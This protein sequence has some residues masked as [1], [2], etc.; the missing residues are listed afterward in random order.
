MGRNKKPGISFYRMDSGHVTN[1]KVRLLMN[2]FDTDGYYIWKCIIDYGYKEHGYFFDMSDKD[3]FELFASDYCR[4]KL[5]LIRE[6]IAGCLRRGLFDQ[7]VAEKFGILTCEMMQETFVIATEDRRSKGSVFTMCKEWLLYDFEGKIPRNIEIVPLNNGILP[8][9]KTHIKNLDL[10]EDFKKENTGFAPAAP[11]PSKKSEKQ[12]GKKNKA[13]EPAEPFWNQ[14]VDVW[15]S[16]GEKK[17]GE[18]PSFDGQDPK[19]FKRIVKRLR[20]R[21]EMKNELWTAVTAPERLQKFLDVAFS[22]PWLSQHFILSNL[23]KQF[24]IVI[25]NQI[26]QKNDENNRRNISQ[27]GNRSLVTQNGDF[28]RFQ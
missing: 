23:E 4:K 7:A 15:F 16:F 6:V 1:K 13:E 12:V 11:V 24:D 18:R 8:P 2:E 20:S 19:I 22:E 14:L 5:T 25:Q 17:F 28:G 3:A 27:T 26:K 9:K 10:E 21:A